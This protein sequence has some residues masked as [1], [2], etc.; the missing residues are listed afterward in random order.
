M[1]ENYLATSFTIN[2]RKYNYCQH[3][4]IIK[5]LTSIAYRPSKNVSLFDGR[6]ACN[7]NNWEVTDIEDKPNNKDPVITSLITRLKPYTQYAI[8]VKTYMIAG[9][10]Q[11]AQSPIVYFTTKPDSKNYVMFNNY[12]DLI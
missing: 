11:G 12:I 1:N 2:Q 10:T 4:N 7:M 3:I 9:Q 6:D 5:Y 8:Y